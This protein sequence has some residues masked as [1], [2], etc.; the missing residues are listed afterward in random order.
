MSFSPLHIW[1]SMGLPSK[2]IATF[3]LLMATM[4][5]A[6]VVERHITLLRGTNETRRFL[7]IVAPLLGA[8]TYAEALK[9]ADTARLSPFARVA[10][11]ILGKITSSGEDG[12]L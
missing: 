10:K 12:N 5:L 1:A 11:P 6:V 4:S 9:A 3:L 7:R 8:A 2:V